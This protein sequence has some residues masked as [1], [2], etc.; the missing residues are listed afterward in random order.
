MSPSLLFASRPCSVFARMRSDST[1]ISYRTR[2]KEN[3]SFHK[4]PLT[5]DYLCCRVF[6]FIETVCLK[7]NVMKHAIRPS[8]GDPCM[9]YGKNRRGKF[10][11]DMRECNHKEL[12]PTLFVRLAEFFVRKKPGTACSHSKHS[13]LFHFCNPPQIRMGSCSES[14]V[15]RF[16]TL[17][18]ICMNSLP[19]MVSRLIRKSA[20]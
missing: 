20:I 2:H 6:I 19:V 9:K 7:E 16:F 18:R 8:R 15:G 12:A 11:P 13:G 10:N 14:G 17:R 5:P 4:A 3:S 1:C